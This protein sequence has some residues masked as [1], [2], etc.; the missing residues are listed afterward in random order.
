[1]LVLQGNVDF[2]CNTPGNV[3]LYD[4]LLWSGLADYRMMKWEDMPADMAATGF[5]KATPDGRL[6]FVAVDDAG[7][8]VPGDAREGSYRILQRWIEGGWHM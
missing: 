7:H 2:A 8:T 6:A 4:K 1:M 5:W 3:W